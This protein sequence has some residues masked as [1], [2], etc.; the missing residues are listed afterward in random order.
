MDTIPGE[1]KEWSV[2][3]RLLR[4]KNNN[5][6]LQEFN[7]EF[8]C[9][10]E[11]W[12]KEGLFYN[13]DITDT[14][15][16]RIVHAETE[17]EA[18]KYSKEELEKIEFVEANSIRVVETESELILYLTKIDDQWYITLIDRATTDCSA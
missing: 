7:A 8:D 13:R 4:A 15:L 5:V 16:S 1:T 11:V 9:E 12:N 6:P 2:R 18:G 3:H 17:F 10:N 14:L